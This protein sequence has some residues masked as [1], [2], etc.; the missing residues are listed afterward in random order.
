LTE[1]PSFHPANLAR[2][3]AIAGGSFEKL[4]VALPLG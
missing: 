1:P 4:V 2:L 3:S